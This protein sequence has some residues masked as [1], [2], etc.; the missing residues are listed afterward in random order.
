M[1]LTAIRSSLLGIASLALG[2][3]FA[4]ALPFVALATAAARSLPA[5]FAYGIVALTWLVDQTLGFSVRHY[6]R[7]ASTFA[8][9]AIIGVAALGATFAARRAPTF[10]IGF[11]LAFVVEQGVIVGYGVLEH[12]KSAFAPAVVGEIALVNVL[13][14]AILAPL[15]FAPTLIARVRGGDSGARTAR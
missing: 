5:S 13:C 8:W 3:I 6:P 15:A 1:N 10:T 2:A 7:D 9:G 4:C 14:L 12:S 11:V